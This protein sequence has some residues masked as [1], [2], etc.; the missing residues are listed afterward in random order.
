DMIEW[1]SGR[2]GRPF[3]IIV[4][5]SYADSENTDATGRP[6]SNRLLVVMRLPPG[7]VC[8]VAIVERAANRDAIALARKSADET[9]R[10]FKCGAGGPQVVGERGRAIE[11]MPRPAAER[12]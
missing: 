8:R 2:D 10:D 6:R 12:R 4:G 7:G 11:A 3:A 5:W 9:A 1:R